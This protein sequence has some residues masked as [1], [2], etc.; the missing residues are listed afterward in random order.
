VPR[1]VPQQ[2]VAVAYS[3]EQQAVEIVEG[4][5]EKKERGKRK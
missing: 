5:K 4:K 1:A 2:S 3:S